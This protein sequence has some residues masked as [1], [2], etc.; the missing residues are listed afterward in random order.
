MSSTD[1]QDVHHDAIHDKIANEGS[2]YSE[3]FW[4]SLPQ[5]HLS[6]HA[7]W[8]YYHQY[9]EEYNLPGVDKIFD[10]DND[11]FKIYIYRN[12]VQSINYKKY[13]CVLDKS[14]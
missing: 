2:Y 4:M 9:C 5:Q 14:D 13:F 1:V 12:D 7:N 8:V 11:I 10:G 6:K 3:D